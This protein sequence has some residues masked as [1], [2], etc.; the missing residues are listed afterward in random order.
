MER[1]G[2]EG[3]SMSAPLDGIM[4]GICRFTPVNCF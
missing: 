4:E 3:V 2:F 1:G